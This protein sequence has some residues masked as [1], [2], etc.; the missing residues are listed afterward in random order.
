MKKLKFISKM[1]PFKKKREVKRA[2]AVPSVPIHVKT[3]SYQ[4]IMPANVAGK[5]AKT[6][7]SIS[8]AVDKGIKASNWAYA[9]VDKIATSASS[10]P[11][12]A[13]I[14]NPDG[15]R[16]WMENSPL[17][18]IL[19]HPNLDYAGERLRYE[20]I[21]YLLVAGESMTTIRRAKVKG[22][23]QRVPGA[24]LPSELWTVSPADLRPIQGGRNRPMIEGYEAK[25][26]E[27]PSPKRIARTE[28]IHMLLPSL[29]SPVNGLAPLEVAKRDIDTDS[30]AMDWNI[31]TFAN[32]G[33]P[34]GI[35]TID[36][37]EDGGVGL[38]QDLLEEG[39][40]LGAGALLE[41][42]LKDA[43]LGAQN[44]RAPMYLGKSIKW[45]Q[46]SVSPIDLDFKNG[47]EMTREGICA[48]MGVPVILIGGSQNAAYGTHLTQAKLWFWESR[49]IP[50]LNKQK[51]ADN[52]TL[53]AEYGPEW[54]IDYDL[55]GVE[56]L[57][58][59]YKERW[60]TA[61]IM[62]NSGVPM[63]QVN[64]ILNLRVEE[65]E[66]WKVGTMPASNASV[67]AVLAGV[68]EQ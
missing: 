22:G 48:V 46:M 64:K 12:K 11:W 20:Q 62:L 35:F 29:S 66:G 9:C 60:V 26:A 31:N 59:L 28:V 6:T 51:A 30:E 2:R 54:E 38:E 49:V 33:V 7:F 63:I 24:G 68:T 37:A 57:A 56:A 40:G 50:L 3:F 23:S 18:E 58:P 61:A 8:E 39:D 4:D 36:S 32:R 65:Y 42:R 43:Y 21:A 15:T 13:Y 27:A 53:A 17:Q 52:Q 14:K 10:V 25:K 55:T 41:K 16:T 19:N 67:S 45:T 1:W 47:R 5:A 44:A 34:A